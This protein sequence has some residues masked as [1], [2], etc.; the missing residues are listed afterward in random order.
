MF[1]LVHNWEKKNQRNEFES[2]AKAYTNA[3][4]TT[5]ND[6]KGALLFLGD[7]FNNST[8]V[9]RQEFTGFVKNILPRYPGIQAFGWNPLVKDTDRTLY[10]SAARKEGFPDF[11]FTE[12]SETNTMVRAEPRE[13]Y[14]IVYYLHPLEGNTAAFGFDIAS[15]KTRLKAI[16]KGFHTGKITATARVTLVQE[17][18]NQFGTLLLLPIYHMDSP[19]NT[20]E[21]R[22]KNLKG[23]IVEV[24]RIGTAV[25]T[26]LKEFS[27]EGLC[28]TIYD[29]SDEKENQVLYNRPTRMLTSRD[30]PIS[31]EELQNGLFWSKILDFS[32]RQWKILIRPSD[33]YYQ[34][35][36]MWKAWIVSLGLILLTTLLALYLLKKILY[37]AEIEQR[38]KKQA[39]TNRQLETEIKDR[40]A[41]EAERDSTILN[42][43]QA[44][45]EVKTLRGILPICS[46]CKKIR[47][48]K[49]YWEQVDV[50]IHKH[51]QADIS[52]GICP[53]CIKQHYPKTYKHLHP[54]QDQDQET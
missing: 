46:F 7:F 8:L 39:Q 48:D 9:T 34:S 38:V 11:E 40:S 13:E 52:H 21:E 18:G 16:T 37:T 22:R 25:E 14:I 1:L 10:E 29:I 36:K 19:V 47:D 5:L 42:L 27:D 43:Q 41:A 28:L 35:R 49:G 17:K 23:F 33:G 45:N 30:Q 12:R 2:W 50:Y 54:D 44:L 3:V 32:E 15:D 4:E 31:V 51:S 24:L 20:P 26:S 6:Y 53:D